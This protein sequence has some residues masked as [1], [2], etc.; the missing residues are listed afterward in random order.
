[1]TKSTTVA[2][3][4]NSSS[5]GRLL[6]CIRDLNVWQEKLPEEY[7]IARTNRFEFNKARYQCVNIY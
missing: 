5:R 2:A 7:V 4:V 3:C 1:V 6:E